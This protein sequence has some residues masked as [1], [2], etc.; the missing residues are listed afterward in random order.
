MSETDYS[1]NFKDCAGLSS[2][3][4]MGRVLRRVQNNAPGYSNEFEMGA[5]LESLSRPVAG[6]FS[7]CAALDFTVVGGT[8]HVFESCC[9]SMVYAA[10]DGFELLGEPQGAECLRTITCA[11]PGRQM[12]DNYDDLIEELIDKGFDLEHLPS[13]DDYKPVDD[14]FVNFDI[15]SGDLRS[16]F[17]RE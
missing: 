11:F 16:Y 3:Q 14:Y 15:I 10:I 8:L 2:K 7:A 5:F 9:P 1:I 17:I 6:A 13:L 4:I 12:P